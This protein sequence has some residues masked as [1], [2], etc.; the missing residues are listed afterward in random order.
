MRLRCV[1]M[2]KSELEVEHQLDA[3]V[4][5]LLERLR[6]AQIQVLWLSPGEASSAGRLIEALQRAGVKQEETLLI[7]S[8]D[9]SL[10]SGQAADLATVAFSH[11]TF[12]DQS[13]R[14]A[15]LLVEGFEEVDADY[16]IR[17][18]QRKHGIPW[19]ILETDRTY[20]REMTVEDVE[21]L[22][23]I[24]AQE[25]MT[26]YI[27]PLYEDVQ[28]EINY[29][30]AYIESMYHYYGYGMWLICDRQ[31]DTVIGRAGLNLQ[32]MDGME[33][34]NGMDGMDGMEGN[35]GLELGYLVRREY[36]KQGYATEVCAAIL[37]YAAKELE[38]ESVN[39]FVEPGNLASQ[40][41]LEK[42]GFSLQGQATIEGKRMERYVYSF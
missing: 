3:D 24:Y 17:I 23:E 15:N 20:L 37:S 27:E 35:V 42:L 29:T 34:M 2:V 30:K 5:F 19:K 32:R 8:K 1:A 11:P 13:W 16:L 28:E 40:R 41:L 12:L 36:Q 21:T 18:Y 25:G 10:E 38:F 4:L 14:A 6:Q 39:C 7:A 33:G 22:Y 9:A 26:D 31:N